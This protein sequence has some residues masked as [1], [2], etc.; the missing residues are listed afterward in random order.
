M[1]ETRIAL[2]RS[3][4]DLTP[5]E[6]FDFYD[7]PRFFSVKDSVGQIFL[8]YW[9]DETELGSSWLSLRISVERYNA[10][11]RGDIS[12]SEALSRPEE[13]IAYVMTGDNARQISST[14]IEPDWL[15]DDDF[16]LAFEPSAL[17]AKT[18]TAV[19]LSKRVH[20]QVL[21]IAFSKLSNVSELG[22][23]KFGRLLEALQGTVEALA[24][25]GDNS[26]RR[27]PEDIKSR[28]ELMTTAL[29]ESSFGVRLQTKSTDLFSSGD[30]A[31]ALATLGHLIN[32]LDTPN[33]IASELHKFNILA[34]SRFK[35]L[36]SVLVDAQVSV[37]ADW[38]NPD[39]RTIQAM[40][41]FEQI[42]QSLNKLKSVEEATKQTVEYRGR[43]VGVDVRSNFFA[44]VDADGRVIKGELAP[45]LR[46]EHFEIPSEVIATV[47]ETC[48]VN[49]LTDK[50][51]WTYVL[52]LTVATPL[53]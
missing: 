36:L 31:E 14:A 16:R 10:L 35:H 29:F 6:V 18:I 24:C 52:L 25:S 12:V 9:I 44:F 50:E 30:I 34:R 39:G 32:A 22:A 1:T 48:E 17:P 19:E 8:V 43:L 7:G 23:R 40:A 33:A 21:D 37:A 28:S 26:V 5:F 38:G 46:S 3:F 41:S 42:S 27:I 13:R 53:I 45:D 49:P 15:P 51:K 47:E 2:A 4:Q 20:R 11:K